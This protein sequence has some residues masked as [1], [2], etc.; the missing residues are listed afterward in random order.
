MVAGLPLLSPR[1]KCPWCRVTPK[2]HHGLAEG[3]AS[4]PGWAKE[5]SRIVRRRRVRDLSLDSTHAQSLSAAN[6]EQG[7]HLARLRDPD[8]VLMQE[9]ATRC[10]RDPQIQTAP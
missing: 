7:R 5:G 1:L 10:Y 9:M 8:A 2:G 6:T 3:S 4:G